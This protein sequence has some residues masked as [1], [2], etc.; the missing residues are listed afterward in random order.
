MSLFVLEP[1]QP[2]TRCDCFSELTAKNSN[3]MAFSDI[4]ES[5]NAEY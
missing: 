5:I 4:N 2:L 3:Q 1:S